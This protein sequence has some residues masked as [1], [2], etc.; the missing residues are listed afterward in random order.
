MKRKYKSLSAYETEDK[1]V[2]DIVQQEL[3][4]L[5]RMK[6]LF[7]EIAKGEKKENRKF[8][9]CGVPQNTVVF[10]K[11]F[12]KYDFVEFKELEYSEVLDEIIE[13]EYDII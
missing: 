12:S 3:Y 8:V 11:L 9:I 13:H 6:N 2:I 7:E 10:D 1:I 5:Q 4:K